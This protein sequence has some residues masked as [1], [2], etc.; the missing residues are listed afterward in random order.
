M[1]LTWRNSNPK[2]HI[3]QYSV[4]TENYIFNFEI[5]AYIHRYIVSKSAVK[6]LYSNLKIFIYSCFHCLLNTNYKK[7]FKIIYPCN[8]EQQ[9]F[10]QIPLDL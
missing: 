5:L 1:P 9:I 2:H 3:Y 7:N 10:R 8:K 6:K 4:D